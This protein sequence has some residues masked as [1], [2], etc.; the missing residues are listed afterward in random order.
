MKSPYLSAPKTK[1]ESFFPK[2]HR[3]EYRD[4]THQ[5]TKSTGKQNLFKNGSPIKITKN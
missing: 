5:I 3:A 2:I 1:H 4:T